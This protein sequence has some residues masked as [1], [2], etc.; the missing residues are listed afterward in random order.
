MYTRRRFITTAAAG[1]SLGA[2]I[3][4][5]ASATDRSTA[6]E[7]CESVGAESGA[8]IDG[9]VVCDLNGDGHYRDVNADGTLSAGDVTTL[10]E[11]QHLPTW[12]ERSD[13]I[14]FVGDGNVGQAD[15]IDLY[16]YIFTRV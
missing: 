12:N 1:V 11:R 9:H 7:H 4:S 10:F 16:Q 15:V 13:V 2:G 6:Q 5:T 3:A 8:V 14:D